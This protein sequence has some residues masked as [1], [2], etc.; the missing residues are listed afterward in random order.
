MTNSTNFTVEDFQLKIITVFFLYL[1]F[2]L[3]FKNFLKHFFQ[4]VKGDAAVCF[5]CEKTLF[6]LQLKTLKYS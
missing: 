4:M 2:A 3:F 6:G 5:I 1:I